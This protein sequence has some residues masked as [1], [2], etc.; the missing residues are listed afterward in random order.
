[1]DGYGKIPNCIINTYPRKQVVMFYDKPGVKYS[2]VGPSISFITF[3]ISAAV[4]RSR[5]ETFYAF[6]TVLNKRIRD[7]L[8]LLLKTYLK[9]DL[10]K[11]LCMYR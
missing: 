9:S 2:N 7:L 1:M 11:H 6:F 5:I 3:F 8:V 4:Q 10:A